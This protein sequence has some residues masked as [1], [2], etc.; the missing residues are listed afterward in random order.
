MCVCVGGCVCAGRGGGRGGGLGRGEGICPALFT[1]H[2]STFASLN[3]TNFDNY[4]CRV[5]TN[6][7]MMITSRETHSFL[8]ITLRQLWFFREPIIWGNSLD[9]PWWKSKVNKAT[10]LPS[11]LSAPPHQ[12]L[13][14]K[15]ILPMQRFVSLWVW[16]HP[17]TYLPAPSYCYP[18]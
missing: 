6:K 9:S 7:L 14:L 5:I 15:R 4:C 18:L 2:I 1:S 8:V 13:H 11:V 3:Q 16:L 12:S 17:Q 10:D